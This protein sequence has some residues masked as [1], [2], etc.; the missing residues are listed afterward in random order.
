MVPF[1][2]RHSVS[3]YFLF[4]KDSFGTL[5]A[6]VVI[7]GMQVGDDVLYCGTENQSSTAYYFLYLSDVLSFQNLNFCLRFLWNPAT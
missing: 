1:Q 5:H 3:L 4:L 7:F 2:A 6:R